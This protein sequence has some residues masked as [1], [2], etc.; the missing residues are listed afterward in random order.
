MQIST[1]TPLAGRDV[2]GGKRYGTERISTHTPLA[3]RDVRA[4]T[5]DITR[6]EF[7]LTRPSRDVTEEIGRDA[8]GYIISTHTPLAG[9]DRYI[10]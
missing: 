5:M 1:H 2:G 4:G 8:W 7:L 6:K 9:R 3:G 10:L